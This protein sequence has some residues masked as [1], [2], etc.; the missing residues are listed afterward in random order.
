M[1][2]MIAVAAMLAAACASSGPAWAQSLPTGFGADPALPAPKRALFPTIKT[3]APSPWANGASPKVAE[4]LDVQAFASGLDHPRWMHVLPNGD[5]LVAESNAPSDRPDDNK[6][7]VG[8]FVKLAMKLVGAG[9]KSA[10]RLTLLRD[11]DG[12]G[13]AET[14][15]V[16]L[17]G[18]K[19]PLGMA[20]VNGRLYIANTDAVVSVPY[21]TG[22][23]SITDVPV[24][25]TDLPGGT[26]NHHWTKN[27]IASDDGKK[28][29]ASVG[30][31]SNIAENGIPA[32]EGRAAIWEIDIASGAKQLFATGLRNPVGLEWNPVTKQLW[33]TVNERDELGNDLVPDYMTSVQRGAHYG[34]P[35]SYFGQS[36]DT[37]VKPANPEMV[38]KAIKPD[39][40][41]GGHTASLGLA[42]SSSRNDLP[43]AFQNGMVIGQHGSWNRNPPAGYKVVFVPFDAQGKPRQQ[44]VDVVTGFINGGK[45]NGR[46]VGVSFDKSGALLVADDVGNV[47]WRVS[48]K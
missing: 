9:V 30:S 36:V 46:P 44:I 1:Y 38:A 4:G 2:R 17:S 42:W 3:Y 23:T 20:L 21:T 35:W 22:Q 31:N 8:Y 41:L 34:W 27:I 12:D 14:K 32:E 24:K 40:A 43:A 45:A 19:S 26:I 29:Y 13:V 28:L 16:F 33:T 47:I 48:T 10:D 15:S 37:R 11:A 25:L 5:V 6:G 39:F 7:F 18:L